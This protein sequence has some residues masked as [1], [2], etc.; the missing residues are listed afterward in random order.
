[1][2]DLRP[3]QR[4]ALLRVT[5]VFAHFPRALK[6]RKRL[7]IL[8]HREELLVQAQNKFRS[9]DP[10]LKVEIEQAGVLQL[11]SAGRAARWYG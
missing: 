5:V 10:R 7:L 1:M 9:V 4:E 11:R 8:A 3:Y 2:L 6:M